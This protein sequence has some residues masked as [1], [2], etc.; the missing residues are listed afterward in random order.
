MRYS[1]VTDDTPKM[2]RETLCLA[3][4]ALGQ[5]NDSRAPYHVRRLQQLIDACDEMRP[6][7]P[8]G[9]HDQRHTPYCGC[10]DVEP[11]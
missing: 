4:T 3:Q 1:Y 10:E 11:R 8:D 9:K 7:G 5:Q 6:L 2:L